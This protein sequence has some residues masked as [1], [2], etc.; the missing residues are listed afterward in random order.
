LNFSVT[1]NDLSIEDLTKIKEVLGGEKEVVQQPPVVDVP[2][3]QTRDSQSAVPESDA[4]SQSYSITVTQQPAE[5]QPSL[6]DSV[7]PNEL[8]LTVEESL[9]KDSQGYY[10][11][12][13]I[14]AKSQGKKNDG[15]WRLA[16]GLDEDVKTSVVKEL[17]A[18]REVDL[19]EERPAPPAPR[20][21]PAPPAD[22]ATKLIDLCKTLEVDP[23][24]WEETCEELNLPEECLGNIEN[25]RQFPEECERV[26]NYIMTEF[27]D[28]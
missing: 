8:P 17:D 27:W 20:I 25:M 16:R 10:W 22:W 1:F 26:H 24:E 14:H 12:S 15:T 19:V 9:G 21:V 7:T 5:S 4:Q 11:D 18:F 28:E 2:K 13:R 3:L 6:F 23:Q